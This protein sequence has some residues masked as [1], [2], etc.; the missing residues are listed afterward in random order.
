MKPPPKCARDG[1]I[2]A[3]PSRSRSQTEREAVGIASAEVSTQIWNSFCLR[4]SVFH[5]SRC[6]LDSLSK[7]A[8]LFS[9]VY[10][11]ILIRISLDADWCLIDYAIGTLV[12]V[13]W[14][15]SIVLVCECLE[16]RSLSICRFRHFRFPTKGN[17]TFSLI[18]IMCYCFKWYCSDAL[19]QSACVQFM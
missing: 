19:H 16:F 18:E 4:L 15:L 1:S 13:F 11:G 3:A 7:Y 6:F 2:S 17:T 8:R 5:L 12:V 14:I 9:Q 10:L